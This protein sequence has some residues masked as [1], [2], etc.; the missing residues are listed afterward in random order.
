MADWPLVLKLGPG[1]IHH[2]H[3]AGNRPFLAGILNVVARA[4]APAD[5]ESAAVFQGAARR[6]IPAV[7]AP[8]GQDAA[9]S[10]VI[11]PDGPAA[12]AASFVTELRRQTTAILQ[13]SLGEERLR[14]LRAEGQ[15]MDDDHV[16]AYT[17]D[18]IGRAASDGT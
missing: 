16:V 2:H 11:S 1:A 15:A 14:Q 4:L 18:A 5:P 10:S 8:R 13:G 7:H 12:G 17:L 9:S 3:W 6:L